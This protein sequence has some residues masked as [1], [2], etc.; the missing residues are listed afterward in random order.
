MT[1]TLVV[2]STLSPH[3]V[4]LTGSFQACYQACY[5]CG[6]LFAADAAGCPNEVLGEYLWPAAYDRRWE[7]P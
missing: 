2:R 6:T 7:V 4:V 3:L 1:V 5:T